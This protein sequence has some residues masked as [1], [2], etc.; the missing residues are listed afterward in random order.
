MKIGDALS[1]LVP[2]LLIA[3]VFVGVMGLITWAVNDSFDR[4]AHSK[5]ETTEP[6][7]SHI[8]STGY[9][10]HIRQI[11]LNGVLYYLVRYERLEV[12]IDIDGNL[13]SCE[14]GGIL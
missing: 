11:C 8:A 1:G 7:E 3:L 6:T 5:Q 10:H 12:V 4:A 13:I 2:M 9:L 14:G